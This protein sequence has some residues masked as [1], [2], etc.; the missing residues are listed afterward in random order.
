[1]SIPQLLRK[2]GKLEISLYPLYITAFCLSG[3]AHGVI[4]LVPFRKLSRFLG[5]ISLPSPIPIRPKQDFTIDEVSLA[6]TRIAKYTPWRCLCYEQ[7]LTTKLIL[8]MY[9][10]RSTINFGVGVDDREKLYAH[11]WLMCGS[12]ILIGGKGIENLRRM[13]AFS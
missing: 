2:T 9:G 12:R 10:I 13:A 8:R 1:M 4:F 3:F 6:V 7:S 5:K 11:V